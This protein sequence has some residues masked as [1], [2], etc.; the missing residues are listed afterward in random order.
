M[1][2]FSN[3]FSHISYPARYCR[4]RRCQWA[5]QKCP[6]IWS[7]PS[8]EIPVA[9]GYAI[10]ASGDLVFIHT[11]AGRT[12]GLAEQEPCIGKNL[13]NTFALCLLFN[14]FAAGHD[15]YLH[16]FCFCFPFTKDATRRR[17]SIRLFVQLPIKT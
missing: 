6:R 17:S 7:L 8:F 5:C 1:L 3:Q 16:I 15:P 10:F 2:T 9:G 14:L 4:C 13:V 11:Q 12:S